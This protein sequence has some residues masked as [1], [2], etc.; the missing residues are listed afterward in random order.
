MVL[1]PRHRPLLNVD[2]RDSALGFPL[3]RRDTPAVSW[4]T[5]E[6]TSHHGIALL[7]SQPSILSRQSS[8]CAA[9]LALS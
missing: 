8:S 4:N 5:Y 2:S 7:P 6:P 3:H 9:L 1:C